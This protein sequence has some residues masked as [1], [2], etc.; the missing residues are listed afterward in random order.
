M[1][2]LALNN[3]QGVF[4]P[5]LV[6]PEQLMERSSFSDLSPEKELVYAILM[7]AIHCIKNGM[8]PSSAKTYRLAIEARDWVLG[9][10]ELYLYS[11]VNICNVLNIDPSY[12]RCALRTSIQAIPVK[13]PQKE[14]DWAK[15]S[16]MVRKKSQRTCEICGS[17]IERDQLYRVA[18]REG[19]VVAAHEEPCV[20][21]QLECKREQLE[22]RNICKTQE[23]ASM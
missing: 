3:G 1:N 16:L 9:D 19:E 17:E 6:L 11:F 14:L 7:D 23:P 5:E 8:L 22:G 15:H 4:V 10:E 2:N 13:R 20:R 12:L 21:E 18:W